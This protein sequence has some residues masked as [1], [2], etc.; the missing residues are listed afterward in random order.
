MCFIAIKICILKQQII[1][2]MN[3]KKSENKDR[4]VF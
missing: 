1:S 2:R 4:N 3:N